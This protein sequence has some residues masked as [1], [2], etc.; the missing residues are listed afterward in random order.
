MKDRINKLFITQVLKIS[1]A[2]ATGIMLT[3]C[4]NS[5]VRSPTLE[6][7]PKTDIE[8]DAFGII[9]KILELGQQSTE[10]IEDLDREEQEIVE[11]IS[12]QELIEYLPE[13]PRKW[14]AEEP[15]GQSNSFGNY[16]VSP[17]K[18]TYSYQDK[19]MTVSIFDWAFNSALYL[20]FLLTTE[21][22]QESTEGYN[23]GIEIDNIPGRE[24]FLQLLDSISIPILIILAENA[25]PKSKAEMEAM[26]ELE[27][28]Q[29]VWLEGTLGIYE[30]YPEAVTEAIQNF[31]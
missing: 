1:A 6:I 4:D 31:L 30:E 12:F 7:E 9:Q 22:S 20:P 2:I 25:P 18:Q 13:P 27:Q 26:A 23:K 28:V 16:K 19:Q 14:K 8:A 21:F 5:Y 15:K 10:K 29:T 24:A 3:S 17:V 11:P